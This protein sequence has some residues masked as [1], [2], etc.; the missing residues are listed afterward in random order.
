[1]KNR[2]KANLQTMILIKRRIQGTDFFKINFKKGADC[3]L[4]GIVPPNFINKFHRV[5]D[6][7]FGK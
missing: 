1:M 7:P 2:A 5:L 4:K 3:Q 6:K